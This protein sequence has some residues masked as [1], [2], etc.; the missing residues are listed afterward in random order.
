MKFK[1]IITSFVILLCV[2][3]YFATHDW[4]NLI[5]ATL[6]NVAVDGT[7]YVKLNSGETVPLSMVKVAVYE[8]SFISNRMAA[9]NEIIRNGSKDLPSQ[10][11]LYKKRKSEI[12]SNEKQSQRIAELK[13]S[14]T[15]WWQTYQSSQSAYSYQQYQ[16]ALAAYQ[17]ESANGSGEAISQAYKDLVKDP[18]EELRDEA[19]LKVILDLK[20]ISLAN[21]EP[22]WGEAIAVSVTDKDG[23]IHV[24]LP[25]A[26]HYALFAV[27]SR[28][29]LAGQERYIFFRRA[30]LSECSSTYTLDLNNQYEQVSDYTKW[31]STESRNETSDLDVLQGVL[32]WLMKGCY[33]L[34]DVS[35]QM[36]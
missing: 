24:T 29:S 7:L 31:W 27:T 30:W 11:K 14:V 19:I 1:A 3:G 12:E 25:D 8:E 35:G 15:S 33:G 21:D 6:K 18:V 5:P 34:D 32:F 13:S 20:V 26:G 4:H 36:N 10:T 9:I 16:Q 23:K 22:I 17:K 28:N 2:A